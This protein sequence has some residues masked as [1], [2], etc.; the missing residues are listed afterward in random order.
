MSYD[1]MY[2]PINIDRNYLLKLGFSN[3]DINMLTYVYNNG[4]KF[5]PNALQQYGYTYE[6]AKKIAYMYAI[7]SGKIS[8]ET[9]EE[10]IKHLRK[11]FGSDYRISMQDLAVSKITT[12]PRFALVSGIV[13]EPYT[14]WNSKNYQGI[15][16]LYKVSDVSGKNITIET[17]KRPTLKYGQPKV[18][19]NVLEIKGINSKNEVVVTFNKNYCRLCNRF[20]IVASLKRPEFHHG[21]Y[22]ILCF[23]GTRAYVYATSAGTGDIAKYRAGTQ[24]V[25]DY[26]LFPG[27]I[28]AKLERVAMAMYNRLHGVG[29]QMEPANKKYDVLEKVHNN[30]EDESEVIEE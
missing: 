30:L 20:I 17:K 24:R 12:I 3:D 2:N 15:N 10:M 27:D 11:M 21:M 26:G 22:E 28:R 25:Y 5:T 7:C 16:M 4:G 19:Q 23:E 14:I 8:I 29:V 1:M 6:Q 18:I 13:D 9:K